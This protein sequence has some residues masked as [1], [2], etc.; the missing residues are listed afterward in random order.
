[1]KFFLNYFLH[2]KITREHETY[3]TSQHHSL[4]TSYSHTAEQ[5]DRGGRKRNLT[6]R[7]LSTHLTDILV[8]LQNCPL[9]FQ[10]K[11]RD[12]KSAHETKHFTGKLSWE[13]T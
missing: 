9:I 5:S 2:F 3:F 10:T 13:K 12:A 8:L 1:M 11:N 6:K 4:Q 7:L